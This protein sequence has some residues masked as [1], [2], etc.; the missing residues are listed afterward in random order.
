[1]YRGARL[2]TCGGVWSCAIIEQVFYIC[3]KEVKDGEW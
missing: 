1:V 3:S 2:P